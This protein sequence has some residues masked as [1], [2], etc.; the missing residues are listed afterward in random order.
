MCASELPN[1]LQGWIHLSMAQMALKQGRY[2]V[3][4]A[5]LAQSLA[6]FLELDEKGSLGYCLRN[7]IEF[8]VAQQRF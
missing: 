7:V 2:S 8:E 5:F 1:P 6:I 4:N 3:A